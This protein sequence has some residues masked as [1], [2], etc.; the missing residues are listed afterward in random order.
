MPSLAGLDPL[1]PLFGLAGLAW[2]VAAARIGARWPAH[3][4]GTV[5][6]IDWQLPVVAVFGAVAMAAVPQ[7][8]GDP[9]QR[10]LFGA[11]FA[12]FVL[13]MATDLDQKLMPDV[14]TLPLILVGAAALASGG[15]SLVSRFP[16]W[17]AVLGAIVVPGIL[18]AASLPFGQ[19]A[20]GLG[21]VKFLAG[22]G[23]LVGLTR[24]VI[25]VFAGALVSGVVI[26]VLLI[27]RK[28]TLRSY[29]PFGP[30]LIIGAVWAAL[31]PAA[32]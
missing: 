22:V 21:D 23:L 8:F 32:S 12:A 13:L 26:F 17:L 6:G 7:R 1:V 3:K 24:I 11:V 25:S 4:D 31:L 28:I 14:I 19:G 18:F 16:W 10:L 30:F 2:G 15:D 9:G 29:I 27:A 20:F 5:R